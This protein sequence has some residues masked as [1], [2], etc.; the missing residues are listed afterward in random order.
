MTQEVEVDPIQSRGATNHEGQYSIWPALKAIPDGWT[1]E[2]MEGPKA[3]CLDHID[4]VWT[5]MRPRSL[6]D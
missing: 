1:A 3:R 2:G 6:R 5:D 4:R